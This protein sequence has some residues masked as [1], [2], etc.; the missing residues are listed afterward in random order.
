VFSDRLDLWKMGTVSDIQ[1][2]G[3]EQGDSSGLLRGRQPSEFDSPSAPEPWQ[4]LQLSSRLDAI[5]GKFYTGQ[6]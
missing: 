6:C 4:S 3:V 1:L 5:P 2:S